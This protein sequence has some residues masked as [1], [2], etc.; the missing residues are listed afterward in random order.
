M[1]KNIINKVLLVEFSHIECERDNERTTKKQQYL[2]DS[3]K[4]KSNHIN[5]VLYF[6]SITKHLFFFYFASIYLCLFWNIWYIPRASSASKTINNENH[7]SAMK[8]MVR[9]PCAGKGGEGGAP[10]RVGSSQRFHSSHNSFSSYPRPH[11]ENID[12]YSNN[13]AQDAITLHS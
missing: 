2:Y 5:R 8:P 12:F 4:I 13:E 1:T 11:H 6:L 10:V 3:T 9:T 7:E